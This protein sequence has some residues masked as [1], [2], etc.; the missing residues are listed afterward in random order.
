MVADA[1]RTKGVK[2]ILTD[3]ERE[4]KGLNDVAMDVLSSLAVVG[5][6]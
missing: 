5:T 2:K 4:L 6:Y 1:I 3:L